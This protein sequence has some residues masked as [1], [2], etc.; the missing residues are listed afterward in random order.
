MRVLKMRVPRAAEDLWMDRS[1]LNFLIDP[2]NLWLCLEACPLT[3]Y[4][5]QC[6][7]SNTLGKIIDKTIVKIIGKCIGKNIAKYIVYRDIGI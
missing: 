5:W 2:F 4:C 1:M 7:L 6:K 3:K